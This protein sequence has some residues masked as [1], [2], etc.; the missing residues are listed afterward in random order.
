MW[1]GIV[2]ALLVFGFVLFM[3]MLPRMINDRRDKR[4][5]DQAD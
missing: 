5:G 2:V 1:I 4:E 3:S